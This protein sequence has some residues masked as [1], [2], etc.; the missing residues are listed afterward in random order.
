MK[1]KLLIIFLLA[2]FACANP[3]PPSGGPPDKSPPVILSYSPAQATTNFDRDEITIEF[4]KYMNKNSVIENIFMSPPVK[5]EYEWSGKELTIS[6][7]EPLD[8]GTTYVFSLGTDYSDMKQ[9]KPVDAFSLIF[10]T[11]SYLDSGGI[12][13]KVYNDNPAGVYVYAYKIDAINPDTLNPALTK[14][15][16]R[17]QVGTSG[18]FELLALKEGTYRIIAIRDVFKN[19]VYDEGTDGFGAAPYDVEVKPDSIPIINLKIGSPKDKS[20]PMLFSAVA[21]YSNLIE[22]IFSEPIDT[23]SVT[24]A[25]FKLTDTSGTLTKNIAGAMI[26]S[27]SNDKVFIIPAEPLDTIHKW[28]ISGLTEPSICVEDTSGNLIQDTSNT[29]FFYSVAETDT[30]L[31]E[32]MKLPFKDST[33][34]ISPNPDFQIIFNRPFVIAD[35]NKIASIIDKDSINVNLSINKKS[36]NILSI[37]SNSKLEPMKKYQLLLNLGLLKP[38]YGPVIADTILSL[39]FK[40]KDTRNWGS[41]KGNIKDMTM[42]DSNFFIIFFNKD[43]KYISTVADSGKWEIPSLP[44][45]KY[46]VEMFRD[47]DKNGKYSFGN[48]FPFKHSEPFVFMKSETEIPARWSIN[49]TLPNITK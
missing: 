46:S 8:S 25:S 10:S 45:G 1:H 19:E 44:E 2:L 6:F 20:G 32:I 11:G 27:N 47:L 38:V 4:N 40:I 33:E 49:L 36:D 14:P 26:S 34:N 23:S 17:T 43:N 37:T 12:K 15:N 29:V 41:A 16:Y 5:M 7:P 28:K 24:A 31:L 3:Q 13:G 42:A 48:A 35:T 18:V 9:N 22:L 30:T 21:L 39:R